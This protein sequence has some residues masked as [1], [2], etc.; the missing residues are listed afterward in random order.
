MKNQTW[1][2]RLKAVECQDSSFL[3]A[4][5][6]L[7][8]Q[9]AGG[10]TVWDADDL[11]YIDLCAGFGVLALGHAHEVSRGV[12][13]R[14]AALAGQAP[15]MHAMGDVYPSTKKV[16][17]MEALV[18]LLPPHLTKAALALTGGQAVELA[19]KTAILA[20]QSTGFIVFQGAYHGLDLG[21]LPLVSREDFREPFASW[22]RLGNVVRLEYGCSAEELRACIKQLKDVGVGFAG[23][24]AEPIQGRSGVR[25]PPKGWLQLLKDQCVA[26]NGLL[27][28]DEIFT[29]LGRTGRV[30]FAAD[31]ECDLLCLGKALGGGMPLS[32]CVG[33]E[34]AMGA[35]PENHGEAIHTGTFFG[36]PLS[37]EMALATLE[38]MKRE[39][40]F[41]RSRIV[42]AEVLTYLRDVFGQH[43]AVKD[44]RGEGLMMAIE[45]KEDGFGVRLMDALR[46]KGVIALCSGEKGQCLS[47]T[48]ALTIDRPV[49]KEAIDRI[50]ATLDA[51]E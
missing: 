3:A 33:T 16:E 14:H 37:C 50:R 6:P 11:P 30:T 28:F 26:E 8:F 34:K 39:N 23:I 27:I 20:T 31:V 40:I 9:T 29:G 22:Q 18:G 25:I 36:H 43:K 49:L 41:E 7:V 19:V 17:L 45:F 35:W 51:L 42:G 44:I 21:L 13:K 47:I 1:I 15:L 2:D 12:F 38:Y 32:A 46:P 48:P 24:I 4:N 10:S 5:P